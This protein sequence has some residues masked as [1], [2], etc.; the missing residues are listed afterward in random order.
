MTTLKELIDQIHASEGVTK[1]I[2]M[3]QLRTYLQQQSHQSILEEI[4]KI[5]ESEDLNVLIGA[6]MRGELFYAVMAQG[7]RIRGMV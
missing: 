1:L 7:A 2:I 4:S 5:W 3:F 6:G